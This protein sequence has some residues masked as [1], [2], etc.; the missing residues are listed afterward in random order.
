MDTLRLRSLLLIRCRAAVLFTVFALPAHTQESPS[1]AKEAKNPFADLIDLQFIYDANLNVGPNR[2]TQDVLTFQP[3]IPF[4][5]NGDLS[6]ITRTILPVIDQPALGAGGP[7]GLGDTQLDAWISPTRTGALV[8][9]IGP[10]FQ[11]PTASNNAL[12][13]GKWGAGP[14]AGLQWSGEQWTFGALI[15]N[16]WSFAGADNRAAVNQMQLE[17]TINYSFASNPN[18]YLSFSPTI[19][20]NWKASGEERW[21]VPVSLGVGQLVKIGKQSINLQATAYYN[22]I[23]PTGTSNWTLE[24][25]AQF[26]FPH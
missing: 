13:Q 16:I 8:W 14:T 20:A 26:L 24:V 6:L 10:V 7:L 4:K 5:L 15:N 17:P 21:T 22:V 3:L 25:L 1:L 9:G 11:L 23:A 18:G 19:V 2:N 12:G